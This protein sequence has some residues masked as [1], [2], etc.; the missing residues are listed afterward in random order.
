[1]LIL[2]K[3]CRFVKDWR[4]IG[5]I[6]S[7][8]GHKKSYGEPE[9]APRSWVWHMCNR[10]SLEYSKRGA[11][12]TGAALKSAE[13]VWCHHVSMDHFSKEEDSDKTQCSKFKHNARCSYCNVRPKLQK[14]FKVALLHFK[15]N[16]KKRFLHFCMSLIVLRLNLQKHSCF[17]NFN[18]A[19]CMMNVYDFK[20]FC[21]WWAWLIFTFLSF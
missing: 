4:I 20:L 19:I 10:S 14:C 1:M 8:G 16:A 13:T 11:C 15:S 21:V 9:L 6:W 7:L 17:Q 3:F 2:W 5:V 12:L 18:L